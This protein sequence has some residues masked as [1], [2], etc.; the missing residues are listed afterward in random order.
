[1]ISAWWT[2]WP[3]ATIAIATGIISGL[4]V[5]DVDPKNGGDA[6]LEELELRHGPLPDTRKVA[7]GGGGSHFYFAY[8]THVAAVKRTPQA[9][10]QVGVEVKSD[11]GYV[12]APP[13]LHENGAL[14][15]WEANQ[16]APSA[17]LPGWMIAASPPK[18]KTGLNGGPRVTAADLNA[19][20]EQRAAQR[21]PG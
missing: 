11:K 16:G 19:L 18:A 20:Q 12:V 10:G 14:Y 2:R 3:N 15:E 9:A 21:G 1:M 13:S 17:D 8:P 5:L 6:N 7:T 4:V